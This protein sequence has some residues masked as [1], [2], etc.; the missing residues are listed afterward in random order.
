MPLGTDPGAPFG[1]DKTM[2]VFPR[3]GPVRRR[4]AD[5][6][7]TLPR[8]GPL[9]EPPQFGIGEETSLIDVVLLPV[10]GGIGLDDHGFLCPLLEL[11][12]ERRLARLERFADFGMDAQ[13]D[14]AGT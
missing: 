5:T 9:M 8:N 4:P 12:N 11:V 3:Y 7:V 1:S 13:G 2:E 14:A 10:Q 6:A